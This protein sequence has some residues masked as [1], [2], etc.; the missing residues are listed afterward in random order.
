MSISFSILKGTHHAGLAHLISYV[1][2]GGMSEHD[3]WPWRE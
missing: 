2:A 3:N 1:L